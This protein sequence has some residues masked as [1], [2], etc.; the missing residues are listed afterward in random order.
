MPGPDIM[1]CAE[2]DAATN[3]EFFQ[4]QWQNYSVATG[5]NKKDKDIQA[6][7]LET[8]MGRECFSILKNIDMD[9]A[10]RK[11]P[12]KVL[13]ASAKHFIPKKNTIYESYVLC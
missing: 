8:V 7:V 4:E 9:A 2:G 12:D 1:N 13:D 6:A 11:D 5:L 3:W 10:D